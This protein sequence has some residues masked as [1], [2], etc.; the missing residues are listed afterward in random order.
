M[1]IIRRLAGHADVCYKITKKYK[2]ISKYRFD[3]LALINNVQAL[4]NVFPISST[5][6]FIRLLGGEKTAGRVG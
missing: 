6:S 2:A 4:L 3:K 1:V 5:I